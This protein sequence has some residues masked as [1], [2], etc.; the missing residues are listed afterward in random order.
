MPVY[1]WDT[2]GQERFH[3]LIPSLYKNVQGVFIVFDLTNEKSFFNVKQ[4]L[5]S[6]Q[7]NSN[8][9]VQVVLIGNK[10]DLATSREIETS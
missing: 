6:L 4:W 3:S 1:I 2:A 5:E 10:K 7:E 9:D 8:S